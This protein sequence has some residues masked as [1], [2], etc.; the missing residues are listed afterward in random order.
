MDNKKFIAGALVFSM[1]AAAYGCSD[2]DKSDSSAAD[3]SPVSSADNEVSKE[4]NTAA[5]ETTEEL[6]PPSPA[7]ASDPN[8]VTFDDGDFSF[9]SV[10]EKNDADNADVALGELSIVEVQGNKML[11]FTDDETVPLDGKVQKVII[12][13]AA[14]IGTENLEKVRSIEFDVYA[15]ATADNLKTDDADN[16]RAPGW[17]GGGG[18]TVVDGDKWFDF[19]EYSGGEYNFEMSGAV[20]AEFKFLL[21]AAGQKWTSEMEDANFLVMRWGIANQSNLLIDNIVFYDE[22]GNSIPL[23]AK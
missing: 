11:K 7:E 5:E 6:V 23:L 10:V 21:A 22:D 20:H 4:D 17:I 18:G 13:A 12:N 8:T 19:G 1:L 15:E 9:A 3:S 2:D 16:V 14:L